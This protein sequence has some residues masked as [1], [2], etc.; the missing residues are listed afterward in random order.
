M[1]RAVAVVVAGFAV[2]GALVGGVWVLVAPPVHGAVALNKSGQRLHVYLG[3][4]ADHF[5]VSA[6][7]MV[8]LLIAVAVVAAVLVWQWRKRRGPAMV[9]ALVLG[10]AAAGAVATAVGAGLARLR[11]GAV[12]VAA[13]PVSPQHRVHY[14]TEA[15]TVFFGHALL[16]VLTTL[17]L[18]AAAGAL[19]YATM[20]AASAHDDLGV[21]DGAEPSVPQAVG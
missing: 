4:E 6:V 3:N 20:V 14:V 19:A 15:P 5:F 13:A 11:Y 2:A 7:M 12:N 10:G 16:Q 8:G 18:P 21:G 1:T 9:V 17:L